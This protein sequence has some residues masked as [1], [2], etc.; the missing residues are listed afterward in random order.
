[1]RACRGLCLAKA[2]RGFWQRLNV[3]VCRGLCAAAGGSAPYMLNTW[4]EEQ[5]TGFYSYLACFVN[6]LILNT[7]VFMSYAG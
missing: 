3:S 5:N 1:V 2:A 6:T 7:Y 4:S